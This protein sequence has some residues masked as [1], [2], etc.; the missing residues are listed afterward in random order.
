MDL[1]TLEDQVVGRGDG[2]PVTGRLL[3]AA[4]QRLRTLFAE[5]NSRISTLEAQSANAGPRLTAVEQAAHTADVV[6]TLPVSAPAGYLLVKAGDINL[7]VG[8]GT[9]TPLRKIPTQAV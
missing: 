2:R 4:V 1:A 3:L 5:S 8:T 6:A 9:G 7:Y